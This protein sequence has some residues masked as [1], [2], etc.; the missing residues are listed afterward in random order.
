LGCAG[1]L[2]AS[3][4]APAPDEAANERIRATSLMNGRRF[5]Y[6]VV[7]LYANGDE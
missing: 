4:S 7:K 1:V 2:T 3:A 6:E 5:L